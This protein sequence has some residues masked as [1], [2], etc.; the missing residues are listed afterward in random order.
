MYQPH[1]LIYL[2][3]CSPGFPIQST[4]QTL[5]KKQSS[6]CHFLCNLLKRTHFPTFF[7]G[8]NSLTPS[9]STPKLILCVYLNKIQI[10]SYHQTTHTGHIHLHTYIRRFGKQGLLL[11]SSDIEQILDPAA[12]LIQRSGSFTF[13]P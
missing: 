13:L 9:L 11:V 7:L 4:F 1:H 12:L 2:S 10:T 8:K 5:P 3:I 6:V